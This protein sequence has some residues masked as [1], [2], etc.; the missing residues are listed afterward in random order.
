MNS[1]T[2]VLLFF[3]KTP[4]DIK[5]RK[6]NL[7]FFLYRNVRKE[8]LVCGKIMKR[9]VLISILFFCS[10]TLYGQKRML[11]FGTDFMALLYKGDLSLSFRYAFA[12]KWSVG[13]KVYFPLLRNMDMNAQYIGHEDA[14]NAKNTYF[15]RLGGHSEDI[16]V[17]VRY[18]QG[19]AFS[20][21]GIS[22]GV[23][24]GSVCGVDITA[25]I[26]YCIGIWKGLYLDVSCVVAFKPMWN[27]N[28]NVP[29]IIRLELGYKF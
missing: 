6:R 10:A 14:L 25:G 16:D 1:Q 8:R 7:Y 24:Y 12:E 17:A 18:W 4:L 22:M 2:A 29:D 13:G 20:G 21:F 28:E 15:T 23:R 3:I 11:Q 27:K 26:A 19:K 9:I 5:K